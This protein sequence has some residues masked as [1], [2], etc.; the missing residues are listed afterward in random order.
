MQGQCI[1]TPFMVTVSMTFYL[2]GLWSAVN[3]VYRY[4][5]VVAEMFQVIS[6]VKL[7]YDMEAGDL[8]AR[9]LKLHDAVVKEVGGRKDALAVLE[10]FKRDSEDVSAEVLNGK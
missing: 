7:L 6:E 3:I 4:E 8:A 9:L 10:T 5:S 1:F 2:L